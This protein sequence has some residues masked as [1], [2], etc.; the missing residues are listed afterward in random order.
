MDDLISKVDE[1][2]K[3]GKPFA[4]FDLKSTDLDPPQDV[5][6]RARMNNK[7]SGIKRKRSKN[8]VRYQY[9]TPSPGPSDQFVEQTGS[10]IP[11]SEYIRQIEDKLH[12]TTITRYCIAKELLLALAN[13]H[14]AGCEAC[15]PVSIKTTKDFRGR[16]ILCK[17]APH[18]S[19]SPSSTHSLSLQVSKCSFCLV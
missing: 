19:S 10:N 2:F 6:P 15:S 16:R 7:Q 18:T 1:V 3:S 5:A 14:D 12:R 17:Q 11:L 13:H 8:L 4:D 9:Q